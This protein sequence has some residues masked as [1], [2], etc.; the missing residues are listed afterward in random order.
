M[1]DESLADAR[2]MVGNLPV[3]CAG[4][5]EHRNLVQ[6]VSAESFGFRVTPTKSERILAAGRPSVPTCDG[7]TTPV[8]SRAAWHWSLARPVEETVIPRDLDA[9]YR[10]HSPTRLD[11]ELVNNVPERALELSSPAGA[12]G[13][14]SVSQPRASGVG[15]STTPRNRSPRATTRS[16]QVTAAPCVAQTP[17][18]TTTRN[19]NRLPESE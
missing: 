18:A 1:R 8:G 14:S 11:G 4:V 16:D 19:T 15:R 10:T 7:Q 3:K 6:D 17:A 9:M 13:R 2:E 5:R 12:I